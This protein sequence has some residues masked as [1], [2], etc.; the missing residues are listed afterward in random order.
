MSRRMPPE[1][2]EAFMRFFAGGALV[3]SEVLPTVA[4]VTGR[5]PRSFE[6]WAGAP[7]VLRTEGRDPP[8]P[9][10]VLRRRR[11][12]SSSLSAYLIGHLFRSCSG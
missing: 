9:S 5:Q 11:T 6:Q 2:V 8:T 1:Y 12:A 3:E 10:W 4:Q 7:I